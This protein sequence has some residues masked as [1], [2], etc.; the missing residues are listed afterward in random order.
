MRRPRKPNWQ[1]SNLIAREGL[2][3]HGNWNVLKSNRE[4]LCVVNRK[5]GAVREIDKGGKWIPPRPRVDPSEQ[6]ARSM[7]C[8]RMKK[9]ETPTVAAA[10][11]SKSNK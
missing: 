1:E 6:L 7:M 8:N 2:P 10:G 9:D 4:Y 3:D 11:E 5:T